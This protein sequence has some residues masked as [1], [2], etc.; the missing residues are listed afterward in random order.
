LNN[1]IHS[2]VSLWPLGLFIGCA[3]AI[4]ALM[5]ILSFFLGE[6]HRGRTTGEPYESGMPPTGPAGLRFDVKYY[7]VAMFFVIFDVEAVF[8]FAWALSARDLGRT[9]YVH[10]VIFIGVLLAALAYLWRLGALDWGGSAMVME[11]G[12][13]SREKGSP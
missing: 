8:I 7:L 11:N 9:G 12:R 4:A 3:L 5:I 6:R 13:R 10:A 1:A 2:S